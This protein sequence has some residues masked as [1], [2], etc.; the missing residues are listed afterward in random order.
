MSIF[1]TRPPFLQSS[2]SKDQVSTDIDLLECTEETEDDFMEHNEDILRTKHE[3]IEMTVKSDSKLEATTVPLTEESLRVSFQAQESFVLNSTVSIKLGIIGLGQAGGKI[4]DEF[5]VCRLPGKEAATYPVLAINTC[6]ADLQALKHIPESQQIELPNYRLGAMRQPELGYGAITQAGV[7]EDILARVKRVFEGVDHI[8]VAAGIGGG[9][10]TG[11]LQVVCEA[12]AERGF[13]VSTMITLPRDFDSVEEKKNAVDFLGT[14]QELIFNG[15][16]SSAIIVDNN[17]LFDRYIKRANSLGVDM[18][19]KVDSNHEIVRIINEMNA[20]TGLPSPTTFDGAELTK[21]LSSGGC[22]TFGKAEI[23]LPDSALN[24][25]MALEIDDILHHGY[26]SNYNNLSEARFAGIQ[27]LM[28]ENMEFGVTMEKTVNDELKHQMPSLIG[29][30]IGHAQIRG[31]KNLLVYTIVSGMGL[32]G[33][34]QELSKLLQDEVDR[35]NEAE[36]K[37]TQ[38]TSTEVSL[39]NPFQKGGRAKTS[40]NPFAKEVVG[41]NKA[42]NP[43]SQ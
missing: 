21:I 20:T 9:T 5:A 7:L 35:I 16:I 19:W 39:K 1:R 41:G 14:F 31:Q 38:F 30:Y 11:T 22:V 4:A 25:T 12:L 28:P 2:Y 32:P 15:A 26:L 27:L 6:V 29:N 3:E 17:L 42:K 33:R 24:E 37:R 13:P 18:D 43:F 40:A 8:I 10:G 34:A 23:G 36:T